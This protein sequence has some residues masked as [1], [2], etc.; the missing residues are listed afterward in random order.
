MSGDHADIDITRFSNLESR[1]VHLDT[2]VGS[3]MQN[4]AAMQSTLDGVVGTLDKMSTRMNEPNKTNWI[5]LTSAV[6]ALILV[7]SQGVNLRV[8]P[9]EDFLTK[10]EVINTEQAKS[11]QTLAVDTKVNREQLA[12]N[13]YQHRH[14]DE[15]FHSL[16]SRVDSV[17]SKAA[18]AEV[19]RAAIGAFAKDVDLHGSRAWIERKP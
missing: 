10:Q 1:V 17:E 12:Y 16:T 19:S 4:Q 7:M 8:G 15:G 18:A 13:T 3:L 6:V 5:G 11:I 9:V 2:T 14:L